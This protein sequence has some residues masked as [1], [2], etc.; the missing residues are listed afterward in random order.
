MLKDSRFVLLS[1]GQA[2]P[3]SVSDQK[4]ATVSRSDVANK[5]FVATLLNHEHSRFKAGNKGI[6]GSEY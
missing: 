2:K 6:L 1:S 5:Q 4:T 3:L